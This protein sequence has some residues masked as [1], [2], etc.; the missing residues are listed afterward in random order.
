MAKQ[1][2]HWQLSCAQLF[3]RLTMHLV[4]PNAKI[5]EWFYLTEH[6]LTIY[7]RGRFQFD[8]VHRV[9]FRQQER[10][11]QWLE[12][13]Q[14]PTGGLYLKLDTVL[15]ALR[16]NS[17]PQLTLADDMLWLDNTVVGSPCESLLIDFIRQ[18]LPAEAMEITQLT[19][20]FGTKFNHQ[21]AKLPLTVGDRHYV[22]WLTGTRNTLGGRYLN[23]HLPTD[24]ELLAEIPTHDADALMRRV[25]MHY[26]DQ[27]VEVDSLQ[28]EVYW[29]DA[30]RLLRS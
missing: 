8:G 26:R 14:P 13:A 29:P 4:I 25:V 17:A 20:T 9:R 1:L 21:G 22:A 3:D 7:E 28:P 2:D 18:Q 12:Q 10:Y 5:P 23:T 15:A 6:P 24:G 19:E 30:D 27:E 16:L 11:Q